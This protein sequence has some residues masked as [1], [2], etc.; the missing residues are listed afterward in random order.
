VSGLAG[1]ATIE[2][3]K[4]SISRSSRT[5]LGRLNGR[6][7]SVSVERG[8]RAAPDPTGMIPLAQNSSDALAHLVPIDRIDLEQV[9][10]PRRRVGR[11]DL[12]ACGL[13][14]RALPIG[15]PREGHVHEVAGTRKRRHAPHAISPR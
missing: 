1:Q 10:I 4:R 8:A 9:R 2:S 5:P 14:R 6:L 11:I 3:S 12:D 15:E 13:E 7:V